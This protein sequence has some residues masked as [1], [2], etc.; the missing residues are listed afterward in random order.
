MASPINKKTLKHLAELARVELLGKEEERIF[1]D[2]QKILDH[3]EELKELDTENVSPMTGGT[4]LKNIFRDD[5][6]GAATNPGAGAHAFPKEKNGF[7]EI[8]PVF[9]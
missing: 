3:F 8:P 1:K 2:L 5:K 9:E 4:S 7:L 6:K